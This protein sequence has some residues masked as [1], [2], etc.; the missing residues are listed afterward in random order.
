MKRNKLGKLW[1]LVCVLLSFVLVFSLAACGGDD[2]DKGGVKLT[3]NKTSVEVEV[4]STVSVQVSS[5]TSGEIT[6]SIA[7]SGIATVTGNGKT[8]TVKGVA[9]GTA[10]LTAKA[11]SKTA[12]CTITVTSKQGGEEVSLAFSKTQTMLAVDGSEVITATYNGEGTLTYISADPTKVTVEKDADDQKKA[13]IT[14]VALTSEPVEVTVSDG[15]RSAKIMVTVADTYDIVFGENGE[16]K[17][18]LSNPKKWFYWNDQGWSGS[19]CEVSESKYVNGA[20][21]VTYSCSAS[22]GGVNGIQ[23]FYHDDT[24]EVEK[25][26][27]LT[28]KISTVEAVTVVINGEE[29]ALVAGETKDDVTVQFIEPAPAQYEGASLSIQIKVDNGD[30]NTFT[31]SDVVMTAVEQVKLTAP[32]IEVSEEGYVV[33]IT[34]A[35]DADKVKSYEMGVFAADEQTPIIR[36]TIESGAAIDVSTL[37]TGAYTVKVRAIPT[38]GITN[39]PSDWSEGQAITVSNDNPAK[40]IAIVENEA[41]AISPAKSNKWGLFTTMGSTGTVTAAED[42]LG[43]LKVTHNP[44][45]VSWNT[46]LFYE[47][48]SATA[49]DLYILT[50]KVTAPDNNAT[51]QINGKSVE[52]TAAKQEVTVTRT[53][54][55]NNASIC[56]MFGVSASAA[57]G[58]YVFEDITY[59]K[60]NELPPLE[61]AELPE[62]EGWTAIDLNDCSAYQG[63]KY[64]FSS[65]A[66]SVTISHTE[67]PTENGNINH[68]VTYLQNKIVHL[69]IKNNDSTNAAAVYLGVQENQG[70]SN[71]IVAGSVTVDGEAIDG[72]TVTV[73]AGATVVVEFEIGA[74]AMNICFGLN[75]TGDGAAVAGNIVI[76]KVAMKEKSAA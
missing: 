63:D 23:M 67:L 26:Y 24:H 51:I 57:A 64:T 66:N 6:W 12:T 36:K 18:A 5:K 56:I 43:T 20:A 28:C 73:A 49:G 33:T 31:V 10:T 25:A 35:A 72:T 27:T 47:D 11:G 34:P 1:T 69:E 53:E 39:A 8:A 22:T 65:T 15:S 50:L 41:D 30:S 71:V 38:D 55:A 45:S 32:A 75:N 59:V 44:G 52:I 7:P 9:E 60:T 46:Q 40:P 29:I 68:T 37:D 48:S 42:N 3:L 62:G 76:S 19:T 13:T 2:G 70:W 58:E 74:G 54:G 14:G 21:S 4:D 17:A 16:G 61:G